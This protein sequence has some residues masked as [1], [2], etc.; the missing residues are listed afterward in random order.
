[1]CAR[2]LRYSGLVFVC[3][4]LWL[5][6]VGTASNSPLFLPPVSYGSGGD[7][8]QAVA[9]A[10][11]NA[12]GKQDLVVGNF[13]SVAILLGR[14]DGTFE[15]AKTYGTDEIVS[16]IAVADMNGDHVPDLITAQCGQFG[17]G[18]DCATSGFV[19]VWLGNGDGSF[20]SPVKYLSGG[21][22]TSSI[23]VGDLNGDGKLDLVVANSLA[24]TATP[25]GNVAV[26]LGKGDGTFQQATPYDSGAQD[27]TSVSLADLDNDG[28]L[29]VVVSNLCDIDPCLDGRVGV[30]LGN[31]DGSLQ[32]VVV[33]DAGGYNSTWITAA[34]LNRD[35]NMDVVT[36]SICN[37]VGTGVGGVGVLLGNGDGSFQP[38]VRYGSGGPGGFG[39]AV[40]VAD[41]NGDSKQDLVATNGDP[42]TIGILLGNGD[43]SFQPAV[44]APTGG[45]FPLSGAL[46]IDDLN[47]D[48]LPDAAVTQCA[49]MGCV[50]GGFVAV[51]LH[52]GDTATTT[53]LSSSSNPSPYGKPITLTA[54]V[55][56]TSGVPTGAVKFFDG[57]TELASGTLVGGTSSINIST[58]KAGLRNITAVYQG[59]ERFQ[60]STSTVLKQTVF[61]AST[62]TRLS[63]SHNPAFVR[64]V[65]VYT[66]T[67]SGRFG[68]AVT[69]AVV[70][71]VNGVQTI[72][73][74][75]KGD[76]VVWTTSFTSAGG[77]TVTAKYLGDPNNIASS[78]T[79]ISQSVVFKTAMSLSAS[80]NP[81]FV[82]Q[83]VT[84]L[85]TIK[86]AFGSI[87]DGEI[88]AFSGGSKNY[89]TAILKNGIATLA[90]DSLPAGSSSIRASYAGDDTFSANFASVLQTVK[91]YSTSTTLSSNINP[92]SVGQS[93]TFTAIVTS[94]GP[95]TPVGWVTFKD[96]TATLG[97]Q[98]LIGGKANLTL[99]SL[100]KG[101]IRSRR[102]TF[103]HLTWTAS[104]SPVLLEVVQ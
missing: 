44:T 7:R 57:S 73:V 54:E 51:L 65:V 41:V 33:Y 103:C 11:L 29:D 24:S 71:S 80:P 78:P 50:H 98:R 22:G 8:P 79:S 81:S 40:A 6:P 101:T 58:I 93:V 74:T 90:I 26:L 56:S 68:G 14:G 27:A 100:T 25:E 97:V 104:G 37:S 35:G 38:A 15:P 28:H 34:D 48:G 21:F 47:Q 1:M 60:S 36:F 96:G 99:S 69:G 91:R 16:S 76:T 77:R 85:A 82:G 89:G 31:P 9:I 39:G 64:Q 4:Y 86:S 92:S 52:V 45:S 59:S 42:A 66:A 23:K 67:V 87:P 55:Q 10:D 19:E 95:T 62:F 43:G 72:N 70:F 49:P 30:L 12:D 102:Y 63:S 88:I 53:T 5:V 2:A 46:A 84:F 17:G 32:P 75:L 13:D 3:C 83:S 20:Q 94:S 61:K 18:T